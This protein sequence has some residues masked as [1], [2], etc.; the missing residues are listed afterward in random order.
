MT[1]WRRPWQG[2]P[3][4]RKRTAIAVA[5]CLVVG[6]LAWTVLAG[7]APATGP[8][9]AGPVTSTGPRPTGPTGTGPA[10]SGTGPAPTGAGRT[11]PPGS[12]STSGDAAAAGF[13]TELGAIDPALVADPARALRSGQEVCQNLRSA[14]P[15][16][17]VVRD[18]GQLFG[19]A[20]APVD[21]AKATLIVDAVR[22]HLCPG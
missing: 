15:F 20:N 19:T 7:G 12:G 17:D 22:N 13:L 11:S 14:T 8:H 18:A 6:A 10:P 21:E 3:V 5:G 16:E 2:W 9:A 4:G 1:G